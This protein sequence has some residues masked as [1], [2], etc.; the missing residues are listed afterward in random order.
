MALADVVTRLAVVWIRGRRLTGAALPAAA[1]AV[2]A[3]AGRYAMTAGCH[4]R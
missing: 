2:Q 4:H 1:A 3:G